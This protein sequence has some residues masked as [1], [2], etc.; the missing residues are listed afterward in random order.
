M[1][2][3]IKNKITEDIIKQ[4]AI[5][6]NNIFLQNISDFFKSIDKPNPIDEL[7]KLSVK[8]FLQSYMLVND[9]LL[10][11]YFS[12]EIYK[13]VN[14]DLKN[15]EN[16][17][18]LKE[19]II[20]YNINQTSGSNAKI[21]ED[22]KNDETLNKIVDYFLNNSITKG[23]FNIEKSL[24][25]IYK[26][27]KYIRPDIL[28]TDL[29]NEIRS[30][31]RFIYIS[32][33]ID[34]KRDDEMKENKKNIEQISKTLEKKLK[35]KKAD[36]PPIPAVNK[37]KFGGEQSFFEKYKMFIILAIVLGVAYFIYTKKKGGSLFGKSRR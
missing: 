11:L 13:I 26:N 1:N 18:L 23:K 34:K 29:E 24:E 6:S 15:K 10:K 27:Y 25:F 16:Y 5:S 37:S 36:A 20:K 19:S 3:S 30:L 32:K 35:D 31:V 17:D 4:N 33:Q 22:K 12:D 2:N 9:M 28:D 21:L 14:K 8:Q 7:K